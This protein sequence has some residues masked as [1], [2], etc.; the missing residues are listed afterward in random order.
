MKH[1]IIGTAGHIDHGKTTLIGALTG[2]NTD[3]LKEEKERGISIELGFTYFDLP[4]GR[5]AGII[6][7]PGHERFIKNMLAGIGGIDLV[8]LVVAADEGVMPQ[9]KEHLDI[10]SLLKIKKGIIVLTKKDMVDDEWLEIVIEQVKEDISGTFLENAP[11][12]PVSSVTREGLDK[13]VKEIDSLTEE[14]EPKD[15]HKPMRLPVDRV[16]SIPGFGTIVTGTLISGTIKEGDKIMIYPKKMESRVRTIQVHETGV[17]IAEAG[18][19]VAINLAGIKVEDI[20]RGDVI[21]A[22]DSMEPTYMFDAKLE[23]LKDAERGIN[24]RDRLRIYHGSAEVFG[25]VV[26]LDREDLMPGESA[27]VQIRLEEEIA[28][29]KDDRFVIRF[30]SPMITIGG[31]TILDPNPPKRKRFKEENIAELTVK[32]KGNIE[33][34]IEQQLLKMSEA[35]PDAAAIAKAAGNISVESCRVVLEKLEKKGAI[36]SFNTNEVAFY[37]H[38]SF[39]EDLV[40]K[41]KIVL[42]DFH[43]KNPLKTGMSKEELRTKV[44]NYTKPKICD[45][46]FGFLNANRV[47]KI[48]EQNVCLWEFKVEFNEEQEKIRKQIMDLYDSN[49]YNPPKYKELSTMLKLQEKSLEPIFNALIGSGELI[50]VDQETVFSKRA[51]KDATDLIVNYLKENK[52]IQLGEFRDLLGT[53]RKYAMAILDYFDLNKITKRI[54]DKRILNNSK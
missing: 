37:V 35:Y 17:S 51:I 42:R 54:E 46:L 47:V 30:Y 23:L 32:E 9:T 50:R 2:R 52:T 1:V 49:K 19:R 22:I 12:I 14:V 26:L 45:E 31:G 16:F 29:Q 3:R 11:I 15:I 18:Q 8:M 28:C 21:A 25:R 48:N 5:R 39:L 7:V 38:N 4:S 41:V 24:N 20:S 34:V 40:E 44:M 27:F 6:D 33:D 53:S 13:L 36:K 10:L 43:R